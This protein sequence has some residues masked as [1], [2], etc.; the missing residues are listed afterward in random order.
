[1]G[2]LGRNAKRGMQIHSDI[3]RR[4]KSMIFSSGLPVLTFTVVFHLYEILGIVCE[5]AEVEMFIQSLGFC[6]FMATVNAS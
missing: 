1:M 6:F 2:W 5:C 4:C 3:L